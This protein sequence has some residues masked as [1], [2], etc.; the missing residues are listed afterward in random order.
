MATPIP[1]LEVSVAKH[2]LPIQQRIESVI[3]ELLSSLPNPETLSTAQRRGI[4]ARYAAVLEGNFIYWMTATLLSIKSEESR[5]I[6]LDNLREEVRDCHPAMM[7]RFALAAHAAPTDGDAMAVLETM[8]KVR[9]FLGR[10]SGVQSLLTM[11]FFEA[12]I[13]RFMAYLADLAQRQGSSDMEYTD[14]HGLCDITHT[15]ELF[16]ALTAEIELDPL[17][18]DTDLFEGVDLLRALI[19][20]IIQV[21][22]VPFLIGRSPTTN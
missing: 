17:P 16:R 1:G 5:S 13:Q 15:Q 7:R 14:V 19:Q 21:D 22:S 12:F 9:L 10:L 8:T 18:P 4:I 6:V 3:D 20:A 11:G 2:L